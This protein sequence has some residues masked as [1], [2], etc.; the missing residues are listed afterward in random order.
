[1]SADRGAGLP[2]RETR[3]RIAFLVSEFPSTS[4]TF[5]LG[6]IGALLER[7]H[8]VDV[9]P[10]RACAGAPIRHPELLRYGLVARSHYPPPI[11]E[12]RRA[13]VRAAAR[14]LRASGVAHLPPLLR[15]L[16]PVAYGRHATSLALLFRQVPFLE[17]APYDVVH[18]HHGPIGLLGAKLRRLGVLRGRLVTSFHGFDANVVPRILGERV[19]HPLFR[20][21]DLVTVNSEFLRRRVRALGAPENRLRR[22]PLGVDLAA[23]SPGPGAPGAQGARGTA[24]ANAEIRLLSVARLVDEK[25]IAFALRAV[26]R[27]APRYPGLRYQIVG[28]GPLRRPLERLVRELGLRSRVELLGAQPHDRVRACYGRAQLFASPS[29]VSGNGAQESQGVAL[30]EAQ[31]CGL[32][33]VASAIGGI[34]ESLLHERSGYLVPERDVDALATRLAEL[35]ERPGLRAAMGSTG[36]AFVAETFDR[37]ALADRLV[38]LYEEVVRSRPRRVGVRGARAPAEA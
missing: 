18:C 8:E 36:R 26:A 3:V 20:A 29:V 31:A 6:Q 7:G 17:S 14:L 38:A 4:E 34:P 24:T 15:S 21:A 16:N 9:Y 10:E 1:M 27:L 25:G 19:Y 12:R 37:H 30:I 11:P 2:Q 32:P 22:L 13:R 23:F 35:I 5:V 28:D 33:V